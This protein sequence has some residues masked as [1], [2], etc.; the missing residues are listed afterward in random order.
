M[1]MWMDRPGSVS[2]FLDPTALL[3]ELGAVQNR[4]RAWKPSADLLETDNGLELRLDMPGHD[5]KAIAVTVEGRSLTVRSE[6]EEKEVNGRYLL[7]E[8]RAAG[9]FA[10]TFVLPEGFEPGR[11]EATFQDGVLVLSVPRR[12]EAKPRTIEVKVG[13]G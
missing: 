9:T 4:T 3:R 7:R 8:R 11:V 6:L 5:P 13:H 1:T 10:R 2:P 12:E